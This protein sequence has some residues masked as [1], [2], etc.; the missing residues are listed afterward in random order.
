M[1]LEPKE[2]TQTEMESDSLLDDDKG[3]DSQQLLDVLLLI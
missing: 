2:L 1:K 3:S